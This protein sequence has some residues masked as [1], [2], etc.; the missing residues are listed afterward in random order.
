VDLEDF[1]LVGL[2][3]LGIVGFEDDATEAWLTGG[4]DSTCDNA[5]GAFDFFDRPR[6]G[7]EGASLSVA[8]SWC[9]D[10]VVGGA[11]SRLVVTFD[12]VEEVLDAGGACLVL[13]D[14]VATSSTG[15]ECCC[16][17]VTLP[18]KTG[19]LGTRVR[20]SCLRIGYIRYYVR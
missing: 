13:V 2:D 20:C 17:V 1:D 3:S 10:V 19:Q 11:L 12:R 16:S 15:A 9:S 5:E 14:N 18:V 8:V 7:C 4:A 6:F